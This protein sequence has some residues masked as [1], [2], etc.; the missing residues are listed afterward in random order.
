MVHQEQFTKNQGGTDET[1]DLT[2]RS[3]PLFRKSES[4][5]CVGS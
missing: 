2:K 1:C 4:Q 3:N 5:S